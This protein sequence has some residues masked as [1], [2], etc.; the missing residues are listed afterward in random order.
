MAGIRVNNG[1]CGD[2]KKAA[3]DNACSLW[4][5]GTEYTYLA[6]INR[7]TQCWVFLE[8]Y[9]FCLLAHP[10]QAVPRDN[11]PFN[12][13]HFCQHGSAS[14]RR[15]SLRNKLACVRLLDNRPNIHNN[16]IA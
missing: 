10:L 11:F 7:H 3:R 16:S 14:F 15:L 13:F 4:G 1:G 12:L 8:P 9:D 2:Q 5:E 6:E